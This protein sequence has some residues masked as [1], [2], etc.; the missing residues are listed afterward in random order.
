MKPPQIARFINKYEARDRQKPDI[1]FA[2]SGPPK[3]HR[4][5]RGRSLPF[6]QI[7]RNRTVLLSQ[8]LISR[9]SMYVAYVSIFYIYL[10]NCALQSIY[11]LLDI[12][13]SPRIKHAKQ[14]WKCSMCDKTFAYNAGRSKHVRSVHQRV[15]YERYT[16]LCF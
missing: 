8:L 2:C 15:R 13:E 14:R 11:M 10:W 3:S 16:D 5:G 7:S 9:T 12:S 6:S 4:A 1:N